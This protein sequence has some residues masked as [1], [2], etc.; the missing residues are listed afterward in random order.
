[1]ALVWTPACPGAAVGYYALKGVGELRVEGSWGA[2]RAHTDGGA[3]QFTVD[4]MFRKTVRA[5]KSTGE[6][7]GDCRGNLVHWQN[8]TLRLRRGLDQRGCVL[9]VGRYDLYEDDRIDARLATSDRP[10]RRV[11]FDLTEGVELEPPL[12]LF[13]ASLVGRFTNRDYNNDGL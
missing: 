7:V 13:V 8:R 3:W 6:V 10:L 2:A 1:M 9:R 4:G 12:M 5:T 11:V